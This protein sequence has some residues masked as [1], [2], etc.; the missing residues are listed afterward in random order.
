MAAENVVW[1]KTDASTLIRVSNFDCVKVR[2][3]AP[4]K[5]VIA[6]YKI[7]GGDLANAYAY[8]DLKIFPTLALAQAAVAVIAAQFNVATI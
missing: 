2:T 8:H 7:A 3:D 5:H 1:V 6:I 4:D